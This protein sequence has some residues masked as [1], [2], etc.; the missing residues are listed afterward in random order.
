MTGLTLS[1]ADLDP[2]RRRILFRCW[3]RGLREMDLVFGQFADNELPGLS[4]TD[5][6]EFERIMDEEDNDLV[7]WILGTLPVPEHLQ[8]PLFK[9]VAAYKPDFEEVAERLVITR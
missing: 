2:R 6:D 7:R 3:H 4:E 8:T 1:S 5:L 9:R